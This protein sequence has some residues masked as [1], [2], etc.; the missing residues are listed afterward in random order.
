MRHFNLVVIG[1][2][3]GGIPVAIRAASYGASVCVVEKNLVGG[4]CVN[5]GCI[6]KK[7]FYYA[8]DISEFLR[9]RLDEAYG[10]EREKSVE[11]PNFNWKTFKH[12]RDEYIE[13]LHNIYMSKFEKGNIVL[14]HGKAKF[15]DHRTVQIDGSENI[16]ADHIVIATGSSSFFPKDVINAK[17]LGKCSDYFF[18]MNEHP[19][20]AAFIGCGYIGVELSNV[21]AALGTQTFLFCREETVLRH[22]DTD[23]STFTFE[24]MSKNGINLVSR[25]SIKNIE[26]SKIHP[27]KYSIHYCVKCEEDKKTIVVEDDF[28][29]VFFTIGRIP[30]SNDLNL[31]EVGVKL[32]D[33]GGIIVDEF[34]NTTVKGIYAIGDVTGS[35]ML[36]PTAIAAGRKLA[37]RLFGGPS[38]A[39]SKVDYSFV[40]TVIFAHPPIGSIGMSERDARQA[41]SEEKIKIYKSSFNG[42]YYSAVKKDLPYMMKLICQGADEKIIG[43]HICGKFCDEMLQGFAVA[44]KMGA[45]KADFDST[46]AIHPT[47]SEELVL[48]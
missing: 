18:S 44:V 12:I 25:T 23:I 3:S 45:T 22:F 13:K 16:S 8:S 9:H 46:L 17:S 5:V 7:M 40:P 38:K 36:T 14:V 15:I 6:P 31:D 35:M 21:L 4:T 20:K 30:N 26:N 19:K 24:Q 42:M 37:D 43:L 10:F 39:N 47:A 33:R 27:D 2:G 32:A 28:D 29:V 41:F 48:M 34:Q 1:A 11:T